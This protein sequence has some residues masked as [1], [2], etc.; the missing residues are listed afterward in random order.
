M[1]AGQWAGPVC[2]DDGAPR[3]LGGKGLP[4]A[5]RVD[6]QGAN[7]VFQ[8]GI[9]SRQDGRN[10]IAGMGGPPGSGVWA[11]LHPIPGCK[12]KRDMVFLLAAAV[13]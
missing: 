11:L 12:L 13:L 6:I 9:D 3:M 4:A 1:G 8:A 7:W 10:G 2:L 5:A